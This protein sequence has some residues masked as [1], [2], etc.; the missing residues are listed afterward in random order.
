[1]G[2]NSREIVSQNKVNYCQKP[3]PEKFMHN[4]GT[5]HG[6]YK[7][8]GK[9]NFSLN[10]NV[11]AVRG[12]DNKDV[13]QRGFTTYNRTNHGTFTNQFFEMKQTSKDI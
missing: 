9:P 11:P 7:E 3:F 8:P 12:S 10:Q 2:D 6:G 5:Y 1:M 13:H 4:S